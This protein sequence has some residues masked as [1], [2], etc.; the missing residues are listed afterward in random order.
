LVERPGTLESLVIN[1]DFWVGRSVFVT[2]HTG[3]KGGWICLWLSHL[4]ANVHGY[5]LEA[6][7]KPNFCVETELRS[8]L[9][10]SMIGD[11]RDLSKLTSAIRASKPSV[12]IHMAAQ[13]LVLESYKTPAE[14]FLTNVTGT[15][16]IL[17]AVRKTNSVKAVVNITTDKC[18]EN[19]GLV[20]SYR[21]TDRLGGYDPYSSS[22]ACAEMVAA[23]YRSSFLSDAG[24]QLANVRSG[25]VIGGGD[26]AAD[27]LV[28]DFFRALDS[29][30]TLHIRSPSAVRPWQHVLEP[31]SGYLLLAERLVNAGTEYAEDWNFGPDENDAKPVSWIADHLGKKFPYLSWELDSGPKP[32]ETSILKLDIAK[33]KAKLRWVPKWSLE[34]ALDK[35]VLWYQA[36]K[37]KQSMAEISI[38]QIED[39]EG[40]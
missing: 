38:G 28:P 31:L 23:A 30:K 37:E 11:I 2:G 13:P 18:Y 7:T 3:F 25:N 29:G 6:P 35:T 40:S 20:R 21:E 36:W 9:Q 39:Y 8:R 1:K 14:T 15:V 19:Q 4:G 10:N 34:M 24:I 5:A 33:A 22:K 12:V 27:R 26:W 17:E 16:N 32:H